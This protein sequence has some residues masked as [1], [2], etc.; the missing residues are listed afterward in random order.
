MFIHV[1]KRSTRNGFD[2]NV[3][4]A[5]A[6]L[7]GKLIMQ[8][9]RFFLWVTRKQRG[10]TVDLLIFKSN[11]YLFTPKQYRSLTEY[12]L[13]QG[14]LLLRGIAKADLSLWNG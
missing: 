14:P 3:V 9:K 13:C 7:T 5:A 11:K 12:K 2:V 8:Q 10:F 6:T 1:S 4:D